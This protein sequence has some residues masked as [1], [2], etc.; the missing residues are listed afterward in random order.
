TDN[1]SE[2]QSATLRVSDHPVC[3]ASVA[4]HHFLNGAATPPLQGGECARSSARIYKNVVVTIF[5]WI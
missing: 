3:A 4:S 5:T 1:V 2:C